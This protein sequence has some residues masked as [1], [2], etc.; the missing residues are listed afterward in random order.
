MDYLMTEFSRT[1]N[2]LPTLLSSLYKPVQRTL[3]RNI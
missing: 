3:F 1:V 2:A